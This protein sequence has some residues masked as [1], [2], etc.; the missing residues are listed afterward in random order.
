[1]T[2]TETQGSSAAPARSRYLDVLRGI[3]ILGILPVNALSFGLPTVFQQAVPA[4]AGASWWDAAAHAAIRFLVQYKFITL[5]SLLFGVG[6]GVMRRRAD[7]QGRPW[8]GPITRR[9]VVLAVVG[10]LHA[11]LVWHGDILWHYASI[12]L[13][14]FW[15]AGTRP[16]VLAWL[17]VGVLSLPVVVMLGILPLAAV[18][19]NTPELRD[20]LQDSGAS[21]VSDGAAAATGSWG[22]FS[23]AAMTHDPEFEIA[24]F[25]DGSFG[26]ITALRA[27]QW[28]VT[29]LAVF[30]YYGWRL[31][32]L[33]LIGM[34]WAG[35]G[36]F[37]RPAE[38]VVRFRRMAIWGAVTG[39]PLQLLAAL[40]D[41]AEGGSFAVS[42]AGELAM[43]VGSL[44]IAAA[45]AGLV[46][47]AVARWP[48]ARWTRPFENAGRIAF[49][50]YLFQS[51]VMTTLFYS[52][53]F[54]LF[55]SLGVAQLMGVVAAV[56]VAQLALSALW[57]RWFATGP[58][59]WLWRTLA[60]RRAEPFRRRTVSPPR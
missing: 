55:G 44:G 58:A 35:D 28:A 21:I 15:A 52:Y 39:V 33:F 45:Y 27:L 57:L 12:A 56:W 8:A 43:Y 10:V 11:T 18:A 31:L 2:E 42:V 37:L 20:A 40:F 54:A 19:A 34:A 26:R 1:M 25:R 46:G 4:V 59:E 5:F 51:L 22:E 30:V 7:A 9:L 49:T 60:Y 17:G 23:T 47:L 14:A 38:N 24:V 3:A 48:V 53:G 6:L 13:A 32:G 16:R 50:N 41:S 36:W 29:V